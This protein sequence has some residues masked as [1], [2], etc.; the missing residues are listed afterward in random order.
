MRPLA[1]L[2]ALL[3][4]SSSAR[5]DMLPDPA[6][7][8][9][10]CTLA[11][12]CPDG[13]ECPSGIRQDA[14]VVQACIGAQS[15]KGLEYRCHRDGNYFGTSVYCRPDAHGSWSPPPAAASTGSATSAP[16]RAGGGRCSLSTEPGS[17]AFA[18][19]LA[20]V[21]ALFRVRRRSP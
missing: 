6:S 14:S 2:L 13:F 10:H 17:T 4:V 16:P 11:E 9:A 12:Q 3:F 1:P 7:A 18:A 8:D 5:A 20:G 21:L 19:I 15:A